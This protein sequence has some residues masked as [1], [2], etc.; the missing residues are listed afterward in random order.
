MEK[1]HGHENA[2]NQNFRKSAQVPEASNDRSEVGWLAPISEYAAALTNLFPG[3]LA[4]QLDPWLERFARCLGGDLVLLAEQKDGPAMFTP[5][6]SFGASP[7]AV[8]IA[9]DDIALHFFP[10]MIADLLA[11]KPVV[12][13]RIPD[14]LTREQKA[15]AFLQGGI[16]TFVMVPLVPAGR[17]WGVLFFG[18]FREK[19]QWPELIR[20]QLQLLGDMTATALACRQQQ[21]TLAEEVCRTQH[22]ENR[23]ETFLKKGNVGFCVIDLSTLRY[24][25][26][27]D[28]YCTILGFSAE[29]LCR[30]TVPEVDAVQN[31][32]EIRW[33]INEMKKKGGHHFEADQYRK[34]GDIAHLSISGTV[35]PDEN[36]M[37]NYVRDVSDLVHTRKELEERL[38][39]EELISSFSAAL[40]DLAPDEFHKTLTLWSSR[41][42]AFIKADRFAIVELMQDGAG[43]HPLVWYVDKK[44]NG[45]PGADPKPPQILT[46]HVID[47]LKSHD[48]IR[49]ARVPEDIPEVLAPILTPYF[50]ELGVKSFLS[51]PLKVGN[52]VLGAVC[53]DILTSEWSWPDSLVRQLRLV[54]EMISNAM[55][56][57][58]SDLELSRYRGQLEELVDER[59]RA[60]EAAQEELL[61]KERLSTVGMLTAMVSH[62]LRNPL[63]TIKSSLYSLDQRVHPKSAKVKSALERADRSIVRCDRIIQLLLDYTQSPRISV[64]QVQ[65]NEWMDAFLREYPMSAE[66]KIERNLCPDVPILLDKER[67]RQCLVHIFDNACQAIEEKGAGK[68]LIRV[69]TRTCDKHLELLI[70]DNGVGL[71]P[72]THQ[73]VFTPFFST[74]TFGIGLGASIVRLIIEQHGGTVQL[75]GVPG[76]GATVCLRLPLPER[77]CSLNMRKGFIVSP[78]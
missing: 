31:L 74:K 35:L 13:E 21:I 52:V 47:A 39:F 7:E 49:I 43:I 75:Q 29:E 12:W 18:A 30:M 46:F 59:T 8:S 3:P 68:G 62:E 34:N 32:E 53:M 55:V 45:T 54:A 76:Q 67:F 57:C 78:T 77:H 65:L 38:E 10:E 58:R 69:T 14:D 66:I 44:L 27:N 19:R 60:L 20:Q 6:S 1:T 64:S 25:A 37:F 28:A 16:K 48:I 5:L 33:N 26:V 24:V 72:E 36:V 41:I 2:L 63:G 56:R 50:A 4:E 70:A 73:K 40:I 23:Y 71:S 15:A 9:Q 51:L 22:F 11:G 42:A 17:F 61:E